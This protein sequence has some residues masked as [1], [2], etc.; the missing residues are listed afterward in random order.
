M[1]N[2][3]ITLLALLSAAF[4]AQGQAVW[5]QFDKLMNEGSYKSAYA[6]AEGVFNKASV[7]SERLAA[8]YHMTLAASF[9]QEDVHDSA[10]ARYRALL[11]TLDSLLERFD[12]DKQEKYQ[13]KG[14][15]GSKSQ[16]SN[17]NAQRNY[18]QTLVRDDGRPEI[19]AYYYGEGKPDFQQIV[20]TAGEIEAAYSG[21]VH[22]FEAEGWH[23]ILTVEESAREAL[24]LIDAHAGEKIK[25]AYK[26][27]KNK[28][29]VYVLPEKDKQIMLQAYQLSIVVSDI[30]ELEKRIRKTSLEVEKY[31]KRLQKQ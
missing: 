19:R 31:Q 26:S 21:S 11:P 14:Y 28:F 27:K 9:Y 29:A 12:Y 15:Y 10:E 22:V 24:Q 2:K 4:F 8:A 7:S 16:Q 20:L 3:I 5:G 13:D 30:R 1:R 23:G 17:R 6:L 18:L 25:V